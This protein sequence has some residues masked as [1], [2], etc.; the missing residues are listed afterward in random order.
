MSKETTGHGG[1]RDGAGRPNEGK[2]RYQV[3]LTEEI[4]DRVKERES[5]LSGLIDQLLRE[6]LKAG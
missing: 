6:W 4:V 3:S 2:K 5:N 1:K